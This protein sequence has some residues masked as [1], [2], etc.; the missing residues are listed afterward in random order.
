[1]KDLLAKLCSGASVKPSIRGL[2]FAEAQ[3]HSAEE[4]CKR[5]ETLY[6]VSDVHF[7]YR[8]HRRPAVFY[9]S[10]APGLANCLDQTGHAFVGLLEPFS[11]RLDLA[12]ELE[13][14]LFQALL[15]S[16]QDIQIKMG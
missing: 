10:G 6:L 8:S 14:V 4:F 7:F 15:L 2:R 12:L 13:E 9:T 16:G 1:M 3:L 5:I 11:K